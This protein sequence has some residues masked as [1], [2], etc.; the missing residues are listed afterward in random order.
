[1]YL[2]QEDQTLVSV[3]QSRLLDALFVFESDCNEYI[4]T[5][6]VRSRVISWYT[7]PVAYMFCK[8]RIDVAEATVSILCQEE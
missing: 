7:Y 1:M 5:S 8:L 6:R 4:M 3:D 2:L